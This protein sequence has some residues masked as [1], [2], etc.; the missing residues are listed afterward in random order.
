MKIALCMPIHSGAKPEFVL[1]LSRMIDWTHRSNMIEEG[2]PVTPV[3]KPL[4]Y[5]SSNIAYSRCK[6][7]AAALDSGA[8]WLLWLDADHSF[9]GDT[10]TRLLGRGKPVIGANYRR[11]MPDEV[12][13][14]AYALRDGKLQP[15]MPKGEGIEEVAHLGMGVCLT[16]AEVF[17]RIARPYFQFGTRDDGAT[18]GE[19]IFVDQALSREVGHISDVELRFPD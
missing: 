18:I 16:H 2:K 12:K 11:R 10:L 5:S 9:P 6:I 19:D 1:S 3:L 7:A 4:V 8:D 13:P 15:S 17:R 14:T